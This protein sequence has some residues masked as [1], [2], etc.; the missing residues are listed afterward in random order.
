MPYCNV[1]CGCL[2]R[3]VKPTVGLF[4]VDLVAQNLLIW[5]GPP[6]MVNEVEEMGQGVSIG[7]I[8]IL[9]MSTR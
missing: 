1:L 6:E 3:G 5:E 9:E 2:G 4:N 7:C 8:G